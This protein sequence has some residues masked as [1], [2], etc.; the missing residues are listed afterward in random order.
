[1]SSWAAR[2]AGGT[3]VKRVARGRGPGLVAG[4]CAHAPGDASETLGWHI[5][6]LAFQSALSWTLAKSEPLQELSGKCVCHLDSGATDTKAFLFAPN[7]VKSVRANAFGRSHS[8]GKITVPA[9]S[10]AA[11]TQRS[12]LQAA[13]A[14]P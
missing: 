3:G 12:G 6:G 1:M 2:R 13:L 14:V 11:F 7:T 4:R 8:P 9:C 5:S 10:E